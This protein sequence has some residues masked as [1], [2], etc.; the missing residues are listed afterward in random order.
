MC[1]RLLGVA[2]RCASHLYFF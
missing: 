1:F 2:L